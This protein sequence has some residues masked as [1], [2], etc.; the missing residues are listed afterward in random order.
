LVGAGYVLAWYTVMGLVVAAL[1]PTDRIARW[2][3]VQGGLITAAF[4]IPR[5]DLTAMPVLGPVVMFWVPL[6]LAVGYVW[7]L[8]PLVRDLRRPRATDAP[9]DRTS[10]IPTA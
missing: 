8:V 9:T 1:R 10:P 5:E 2:L 6:A 3:A 4:L 7:A